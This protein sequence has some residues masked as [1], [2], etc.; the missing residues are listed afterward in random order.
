MSEAF[1]FLPLNPNFPCAVF[2][3]LCVCA[4]GRG[5]GEESAKEETSTAATSTAPIMPN[6]WLALKIGVPH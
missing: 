4:G 2:V 5:V 6:E 1:K 3:S